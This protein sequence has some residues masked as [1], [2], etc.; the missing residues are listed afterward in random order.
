MIEVTI[1]NKQ[2]QVPEGISIIEA[3][4]MHD[5]Y[6]PRFCYHKKLSVVANCRICL[7]EVEKVGKPLPAC[8]TP[9]TEN[10]VV[11]TQSEKALHAQRSVMEF[12]LINH[13]LDCPVCDQG[14]ACELQDYSVG[15]GCSESDFSFPKRAVPELELGPLVKTYLTRC[16]QC[17][18]C[19][20]F[21]REVAGVPE[22]GLVDRGE[23]ERISTYVEGELQSELSGNMIDVCPV[24][25]LTSKPSQF[26]GRSWEYV[27]QPTIAAH[28]CIGSN[29]YAHTISR[30]DG[31]TMSIQ[32][33]VPRENNDINQCWL[34]DRDRFSFQALS[35]PNRVLTP[36][37]KVNGQWQQCGWE[38]ALLECADKTKTLL[39]RYGADSMAFLVG[40]Q[41]T[42][43]S[44]YLLQKLCRS[45]GSS[46]IDFRLQV[47]DFRDQD[48]QATVAGIG[49]TLVDLEKCDTLFLIGADIRRQQPV[50]TCRLNEL[51]AEGLKVIVL[52]DADYAFTFPVYQQCTVSSYELPHY[53]QVLRDAVSNGSAEVPAE[54]ASIVSAINAS[55]RCAIIMGEQVVR[56]P[57][58]AVIRSHVSTLAET[59][60][61]SHG[62]LTPGPNYAGLQ[63][64]G[65]MPHRVAAG[66]VF[67]R[68]GEHCADLC[69]QGK[70][71]Y[72][73][74]AMDPEFDVVHSAAL[75]KSLDAA[76]FVV[77]FAAFETPEMRKYADIILPIATPA[78]TSGTYVN[79]QGQWQS[80]QAAVMSSDDVRP[81]WKVLRVFANFMGC[82]D[83]SYADSKSVLAEL[84]QKMQSVEVGELAVRKE[85]TTQQC[86]GLY[87]HHY[88]PSLRV[89]PQVRQAEALQSL[90][91]NVQPTIMLN[92]QTATELGLQLD[93]S[94]TAL[95]GDSQVTL[96]LALDETLPNHC[97][98][99]PYGIEATIGFGD[100]TNALILEQAND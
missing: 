99:I 43:E 92:A 8:A 44:G 98:H 83:F 26:V 12:L 64:A 37:V 4:D 89:D 86:Q 21:S 72:F 17:S 55:E 58:A 36:Q 31:N 88:W 96:P 18:R 45:L 87:R 95:Q 67:E 79:T 63:L 3:A 81:G 14:G 19:V 5:I 75:L 48:I 2:Y 54:L 33:V 50:L 78:E 28:D 60:S 7:V 71:L 69:R 61:A 46:N 76:A 56:H 74:Y 15:Y 20:R 47:Q 52:N 30:D 62:C 38:R 90:S 32:R 39:Q 100:P 59:I 25:A 97:V 22:L 23:G 57:D 1:N 91:T 73:L 94:V 40:P 34:S 6:I 41:T 24:G 53:C 66:K 13:P 11:Y 84:K 82:D 35:S 29:I 77:C 51:A 70:R 27:E 85:Y 49:T 16:I 68:A 65:C 80:F 10:M 42:T 9:I 93:R